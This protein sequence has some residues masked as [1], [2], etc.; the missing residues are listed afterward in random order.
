MSDITPLALK[1]HLADV[2]RRAAPV[3]RVRRR[4]RTAPKGDWVRRLSVAFLG[5]RPGRL[6]AGA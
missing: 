1:C 3:C 2:E 4:G 6:P 5:L